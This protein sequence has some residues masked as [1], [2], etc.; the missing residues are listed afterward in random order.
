MMLVRLHS[1]A[2][3][4]LYP[5]SFMLTNTLRASSDVRFPMAVSIVSMWV[6]RVGFRYILGIWMD[7][8]VLG[9][10]IAMVTDWACRSVC[11]VVR[12]IRGK[13]KTKCIS[14]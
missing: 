1:V 4:F 13:W 5:E 2:A 12:F 14:A 11:F 10:W 9:V 7:L 8:G 3:I 6:W